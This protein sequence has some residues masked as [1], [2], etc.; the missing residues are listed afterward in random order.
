MPKAK[1]SLGPWGPGW[2]RAIAFALGVLYPSLILLD[3][4]APRTVDQIVP[5]PLLYFAQVAA[6]FPR[7]S[8]YTIEFRAQGWS[9]KDH[10]F[11]EIDVRPYFP[12]HRNDKENQFTRA[13]YFYLRNRL[14]MR[15]LDSYVTSRFNR[16]HSARI[17]GVRF[18]SLREPIPAPGKAFPRFVRRPLAGM[19]DNERHY[20]Y[21]TPASMRRDRCAEGE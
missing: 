4:L 5:R 16:D 9:C 2:L 1:R 15:A 12:I 6:L 14:V 11:R 13:L 18:L 8:T 19:P 7:A 3:E 10:R 20:W 21:W 17:G